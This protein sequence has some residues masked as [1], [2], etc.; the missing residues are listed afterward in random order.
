M[1][2]ST[3]TPEEY[4]TNPNTIKARRR[5]M[6]L[7]GAQKVEDSARTADYKAMIHSRQ[8]VQAKSEYKEASDSEKSAMLEQAMRET[9]VKRYVFSSIVSDIDNN[10]C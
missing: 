10:I 3:K 2:G 5:K 9:M 4:S 1:P 8:V 7:N 6:N